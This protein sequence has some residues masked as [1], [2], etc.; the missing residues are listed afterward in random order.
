MNSLSSKLALAVVASLL[1][2]A[3]VRVAIEMTYPDGTENLS[4]GK[5]AVTSAQVVAKR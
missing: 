3:G 5:I 1:F 2:M 4:R